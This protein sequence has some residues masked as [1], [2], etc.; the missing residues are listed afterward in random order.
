[1]AKAKA[2]KKNG[3]RG[4]R[5]EGENWYILKKKAV[6]LHQVLQKRKTTG[7]RIL[8]LYNIFKMQK[9][10]SNQNEER[11]AFVESVLDSYHKPLY[12]FAFRLCRQ[13][14][15]DP[16][17]ADD[18]LQEFYWKMLTRYPP[19]AEKLEAHGPAYLFSMVQREVLSIGRKSK[20]LQRIN[21]VLGRSALK[22]AKP[23]YYSAEEA[24][25]NF[26]QD[27]EKLVSEQDLEILRYYLEGYS[28]K[29]VGEMMEMNPSTV[30]VRIHRAKIRLAPHLPE[31]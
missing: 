20:S 22:E 11:N 30:G 19:I 18:V 9:Q 24:V 23:G 21:K 29:E 14:G 6:R 28:M 2:A 16:T 26:L 27:I 13:F 3:D 4:K 12:A 10:Q 17:Y 31:G 7:H 15:F 1:M 5:I 8:E 25:N